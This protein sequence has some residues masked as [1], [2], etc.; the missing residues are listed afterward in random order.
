M[1]KAK[2]IR[3]KEKVMQRLTEIV[4]HDR[5]VRGGSWVRLVSVPSVIARSTR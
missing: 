3:N 4:G 1:L 2:L 5:A